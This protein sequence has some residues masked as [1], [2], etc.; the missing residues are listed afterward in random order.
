MT[1][2]QRAEVEL[3]FRLRQRE[4]RYPVLPTGTLVKG[5]PSW[6]RDH[7]LRVITDPGPSTDHQR[8]IMIGRC[9]IDRLDET[10]QVRRYNVSL[11][12]HAE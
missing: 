10:Y 8:N 2:Q 9:E 6:L 3:E 7:L 5:G 4:T 11:P 1:P 12:R